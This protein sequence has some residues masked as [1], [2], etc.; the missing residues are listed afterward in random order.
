MGSMQRDSL[1]ACPGVIAV[2]VH[3]YFQHIRFPLAIISAAP[4]AHALLY[5][6]S[7]LDFMSHTFLCSL[8]ERG[9]RQAGEG[10]PA[11]P[12]VAVVRCFALSLTRVFL[13]VPLLSGACIVSAFAASC[14]LIWMPLPSGLSPVQTAVIPLRGAGHGIAG[15]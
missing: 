3:Q 11:V 15:L 1:A 8:Q 4:Q 9:T 5:W 12:A 6:F 14:V 2:R 13:Q 10:L 7:E